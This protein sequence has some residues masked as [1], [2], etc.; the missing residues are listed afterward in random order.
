VQAAALQALAALGGLTEAAEI[1]HYLDADAP[2]LRQAAIIGLLRS[3]ALEGV[4]AVGETLTRLVA[5]PVV[6][7]RIFA[8]QVL[9]ESR[10]AGLYRPLLKLL[11]DGDPKV[12]QAALAAVAKIQH[13]QLWPVVVTALSVAQT[14]AA[15]QTT[16]IAGGEAVLPTLL[17]AAAQAGPVGAPNRALWLALVPI[18]GRIAAPQSCSFL[19]TQLTCPDVVVRTALLTALH[20]CGYQAD[21]ATR[22]LLEAELRAEIAHASW[23]LT[24]LVAIGEPAPGPLLLLRTALHAD[25]AEQQA[26]LLL[27]LA[28]LYDS[29]TLQ[30]VRTA[31]ALTPGLRRTPTEEQRAYALETLDLLLTKAVSKQLLLLLDDLP[32]AQQLKQLAGEATHTPLPLPRQLAALITGDERWVAPWLKAVALYAIAHA[33]P[34]VQHDPTLQ[35]AVTGATTAADPLVQETA[36]WVKLR[37]NNGAVDSRG[38]AGLLLTVEKVLILQRVEIFA[39][40]PA[41]ILVEIAAHLQEQFT[42]AGAIIFRQGAP[43]ESIYFI[44]TGAVEALDGERVFTQMGE[45]EIFG[46][47]ALLDGEPRTATIRTTAPTHLLSLDQAPF[48]ELMDEHIAMARG[49]IAVLAQRLRARTA[50]LSRLQAQVAAISK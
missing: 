38:G 5:S 39:A 48:Y 50:D 42:P 45:G 23:T 30:R 7:E 18:F 11:H 14:R 24:H 37:L 47:M 28:L 40:M 26:R 43:G 20:Q 2:S 29:A 9:G 34:A 10:L 4:L 13:P 41:T 3:G 16:L 46:E 36:A 1:D 32:P 19:V 44:V 49:V 22:P 25:L 27:W 6:T 12:R 8:A 31:L 15:A 21:A 17:Q 35:A 33:L